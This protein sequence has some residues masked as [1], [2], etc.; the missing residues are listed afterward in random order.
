MHTTLRSM[1]NGWARIYSGVTQ[2]HA[3][4]ILGVLL[5]V[6]ISGLGAYAVL[7]LS[8]ATFGATGQSDFLFPALMH[9]LIITLVLTAIYRLSGN[10]R[11]Y[12]LLFPLGGAVMV[13]I[14]A[15]A[16]RACRTGKIAWRGTSYT[17][18]S[19]TSSPLPVASSPVRVASP[20]PAPA[21]AVE[22]ESP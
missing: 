12:A 7:A 10:P 15:A 2:R 16:I 14:Y 19:A 20:A 4:P 9:V 18:G 3:L 11:R 5:F 22:Q 6:A 13:A 21:R 1:F 17:A 8:L